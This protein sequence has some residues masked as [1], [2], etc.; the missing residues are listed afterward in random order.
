MPFLKPEP[1]FFPEQL[2]ELGAPW[3]VAH[4][5][6]RQEKRL[7]RYLRERAAG[8]GETN[9][10]P[11]YLPQVRKDS[12]SGGRARTAYLPLFPGYLFFRGGERER[13]E[14][15]RSNLVVTTIEVA[16]QATLDAELRG[17]H[18]LQQRGARF[19]PFELREGDEVRIREGAFAGFHGRIARVRGVD[20]LLVT[21]TAIRMNVLAELDAEALTLVK[22]SVE[23]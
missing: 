7:A 13:I 11:F 6:S 20:R 3:R 16:E 23:F 22:S 19:I 2:F 14:V 12:I 15:L 5:R 9:G 8:T 18:E 17:L 4:V 10:V 1:D 21:I